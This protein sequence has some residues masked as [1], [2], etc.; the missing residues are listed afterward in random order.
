MS[1]E[2]SVCNPNTCARS[3]DLVPWG[4]SRRR[5]VRGLYQRTPS[6]LEKNPVLRLRRF[7]CDFYWGTY[8][9][10]Q[11]RGNLLQTSSFL[12][13][14]TVDTHLSFFLGDWRSLTASP[15]GLDW[16]RPLSFGTRPSFVSSG[17]HRTRRVHD[18]RCHVHRTWDPLRRKSRKEFR[19]ETSFLSVDRRVYSRGLWR[20]RFGPV[21]GP[22]YFGNTVRFGDGRFSTHSRSS[23]LK[24][25]SPKTLY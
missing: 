16:Y 17:S 23:F 11:V 12:D 14:F 5:G 19:K 1:L 4:F 7:S 18:T 9:W 15:S 10:G 24:L 2:D 20:C 3:I 13:F 6:S 25:P 22:M 8:H 21:S